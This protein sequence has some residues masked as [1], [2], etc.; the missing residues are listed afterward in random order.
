MIEVTQ[1]DREA[2]AAYGRAVG[3]FTR[4][5]AVQ[6]LNGDNDDCTVVQAFARHRIAAEQRARIEGFNE[7]IEAAAKV[8]DNAADEGERWKAVGKW[9]AK[10]IAVAIRALAKPMKGPTDEANNHPWGF[11]HD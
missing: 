5:E 2:A 11:Y 6:I 10:G 7:G 8:T 1:E 9:A 4:Q 3:I